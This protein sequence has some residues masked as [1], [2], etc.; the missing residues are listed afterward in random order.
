MQLEAGSLVASGV[1]V[2]HED[3]GQRHF[4]IY[5][6][7]CANHTPIYYTKIIYQILYIPNCTTVVFEILVKNS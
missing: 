5:S 7:G 2:K 1:L 4:T 3:D 6:I